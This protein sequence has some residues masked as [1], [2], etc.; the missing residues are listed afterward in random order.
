MRTP[1]WPR[2]RI[3][4][5]M[6][7]LPRPSVTAGQRTSKCNGTITRRWSLSCNGR[8]STGIIME[9]RRRAPF[10][11]G[12]SDERASLSIDE[13]TLTTAEWRRRQVGSTKGAN[14]GR[15]KEERSGTERSD[16]GH[17][18]RRLRRRRAALGLPAGHGRRDSFARR[19]LCRRTT[20][21]GAGDRLRREG[22][23]R[24]DRPVPAGGGGRG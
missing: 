17:P 23:G 16:R 2:F 6:R 12:G 18:G 20:G 7:T 19:R 5:V 24:A 9:G 14:D 21:Y 11:P 3:F 22:T 4:W 15:G 13:R 8:K 1:T 10:R